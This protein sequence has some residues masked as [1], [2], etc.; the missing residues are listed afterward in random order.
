MLFA[1]FERI[2]S[3]CFKRKYNREVGELYKHFLLCILELKFCNGSDVALEDIDKQVEYVIINELIFSIKKF[4]DFDEFLNDFNILISNTEIS[5]KLAFN[6][7]SQMLFFE[8]D[9]ASMNVL[10]KL[11][12]LEVL[13]S[14]RY[15]FSN[16][17]VQNDEKLIDLIFI[18]SMLLIEFDI[19]KRKKRWIFI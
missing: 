14:K 4:F 13:S 3:Y 11:L 12:G 18:R 7:V 5:S 9:L 19:L 15:I 2:G 16:Q 10:N 1:T 17:S 6:L 8:Y